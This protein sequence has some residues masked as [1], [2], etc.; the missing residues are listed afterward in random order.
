MSIDFFMGHLGNRSFDS[1]VL[2]TFLY[3]NIGQTETLILK[4][5]SSFIAFIFLLFVVQ[6]E[7]AAAKLEWIFN[8]QLQLPCVSDE[9]RMALLN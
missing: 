6:C 7:L 3:V 1:S 9:P 5:K 4:P 8:I 2:H